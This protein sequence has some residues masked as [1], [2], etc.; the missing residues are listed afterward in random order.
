MSVEL[1]VFSWERQKSDNVDIIHDPGV[2]K[3]DAHLL[4]GQRILRDEV[5][6]VSNLRRWINSLRLTVRDFYNSVCVQSS[7]LN[8]LASDT[9]NVFYIL[10]SAI[11]GIVLEPAKIIRN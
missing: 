7:S 4:V 5:G 10:Q 6:K 11:F 3:R 9:K 8:M 1:L 2:R